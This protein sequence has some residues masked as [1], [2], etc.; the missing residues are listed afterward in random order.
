MAWMASFLALP[1]MATSNLKKATSR[2]ASMS[3]NKRH[4]TCPPSQSV[5]GQP[6]RLRE[7]QTTAEDFSFT[8]KPEYARL[9]LS[10]ERA[11]GLLWSR[12]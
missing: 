10:S 3:G 1:F 7:G 6:F 11:R 5:T 2:R 4:Y 12:S 8:L 9:K